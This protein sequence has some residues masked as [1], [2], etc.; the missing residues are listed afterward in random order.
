MKSV[1]YSW[2][3]SA[4]MKSELERKARLRKVSVSSLLDQA[5]REYLKSSAEDIANDEAQ[6]DLH[7]HIQQFIGVLDGGDATRSENVRKLVR[8]RLRARH[9]A[10]QRT[11]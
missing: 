3:L 7:S 4:E 10:S 5:V 6:R 2:R 9:R 11:D 8:R 1:V